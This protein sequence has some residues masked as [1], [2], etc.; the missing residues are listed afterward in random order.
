MIVSDRITDENMDQ[1]EL[2]IATKIV[3]FERKL[4]KIDTSING[5]KV[6]L[7]VKH[8]NKG[9]TEPKYNFELEVQSTLT[10]GELARAIGEV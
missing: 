3:L 1:I 5:A 9:F 4:A 2:E 6:K 7:Q 8:V 10:I